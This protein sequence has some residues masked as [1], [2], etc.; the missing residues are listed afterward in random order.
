M[1]NVLSLL[2]LLFKKT[3]VHKYR[4]YHTTYHII[5]ILL[6]LLTNESIFKLI[7]TVKE[8]GLSY[9]S[10]QFNPMIIKTKTTY[11]CSINYGGLFNS[12]FEML[13]SNSIIIYIKINRVVMKVNG[14]RFTILNRKKSALFKFRR[15]LEKHVIYY[16][17][18]LY[19]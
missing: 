16:L 14:I 1:S 13:T 6:H 2:L 11:Q 3:L 10:V 19:Q 15:L 18:N 9:L 4:M 8:T 17:F 12:P 7:Y 5:I